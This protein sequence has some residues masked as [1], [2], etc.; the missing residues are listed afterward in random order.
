MKVD[1]LSITFCKL[2]LLRQKQG[3]LKN[4]AD[5]ICIGSLEVRRCVNGTASR[6][7]SPIAREWV[8]A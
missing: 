4:V 3:E 2:T 7:T 8:R 1:T 5:Y 6:R